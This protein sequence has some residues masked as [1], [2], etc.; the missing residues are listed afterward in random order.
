MP[1]YKIVMPP[2]TFSA[3]SAAP[4][5]PAP[6]MI[7]LVREVQ[8][9]PAWEFTGHVEAPRSEDLAQRAF[10]PQGQIQPS[11]EPG[12]KKSGF[13]RALKRFFSGSSE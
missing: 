11:R 12:K 2:L 5:E 10:A 3:S 4:P 7:L 13:W 6:D 9:E 8:V 1:L